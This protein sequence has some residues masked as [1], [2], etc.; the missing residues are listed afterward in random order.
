MNAVNLVPT[1]LNLV[2]DNHVDAYT[3]ISLLASKQEI[4]GEVRS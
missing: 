1:P 4:K 2:I 3:W